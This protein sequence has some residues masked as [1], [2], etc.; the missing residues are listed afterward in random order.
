[1]SDDIRIRKVNN[2]FI[3]YDSPRERFECTTGSEYVFNTLSGLVGHLET[4]FDMTLEQEK[5]NAM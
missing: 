3:V 4:C 1:M 5:E 2:G